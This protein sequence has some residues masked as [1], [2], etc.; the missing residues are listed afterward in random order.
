VFPIRNRLKQGDALT[1]LL[2]S[3][4]L[5]YAI[6]W[7]QVNQ[8]SLQINGTHQPMIY[9]NGVNIFV[10]SVQTIKKKHRTFASP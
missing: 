4:A 10:G 5:E 9:A 1:P 8:D 6:T 7:A 3:F 2:F